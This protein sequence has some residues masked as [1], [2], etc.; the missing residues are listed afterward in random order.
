VEPQEFKDFIDW[1]PVYPDS[2]LG[3]GLLYQE[4][5]AIMYGRY[6]SF[7]SL[8]SL[9]LTLCVSDGVPWLGFDTPKGGRSTLYLQAEVPHSLMHK[10]FSKMWGGW[11][12]NGA[13]PSNPMFLWTEPYMKLDTT[14]G[15]DRLDQALSATCPELV[16]I[17][18]VYRFMAG[19]ILDPNSVRGLLDSLD[20]LI[21]KH[22]IALVLVAHPRKSAIDEGD[23]GSDDLLGSVFFSAW[24]DSVIKVTRLTTKEGKLT[25]RMKVNFDVVRYAEDLLE[26]QEVILDESNLQFNLS[27]DTIQL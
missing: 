23:W 7:K 14:K 13:R 19:N 1:K 26:E 22:K 4:G 17:D 10:G 18:P 16:V 9:F 12:T 11:T 6:K 27:K 21:A 3:K 5:K 8:L 20:G 24:A 25:N 2:V 15:H